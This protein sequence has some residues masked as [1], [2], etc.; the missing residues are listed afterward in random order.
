MFAQ[1]EYDLDKLISYPYELGKY[2]IMQYRANVRMEPTRNSVV[3]AVLSFH[4]EIEILENSMIAERIN[5]VRS[6]WYKIKY[7][8]I[9]GYT[10]GGNI[11]YK[12]L[13]TDIDENGINDYFYVRYSHSPGYETLFY[14]ET[15]DV[16]IY[17][18]NHRIGTDFLR[19]RFKYGLWVSCEFT[20]RDG[21]VLICLEQSG[22]DHRPW[23]KHYLK[24]TSDG[25]IE[26]LRREPEI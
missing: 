23:Y 18:N 5:G 26:Y 13:V 11:A 15:D 6:F 14:P 17:I 20:D 19:D 8:K 3:V 16:V 10:F 4:D 24:V 21:Y 12:T 2:H 25:K 7:G 1:D 22:G 9:I